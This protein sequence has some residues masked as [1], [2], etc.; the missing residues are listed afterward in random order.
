MPS[1]ADGPSARGR[2]VHP[3]G[4]WAVSF[5]VLGKARSWPCK[6]LCSLR[7]IEDN[8]LSY[9]ATDGPTLK[10]PLHEQRLD[11]RFLASLSARPAGPPHPVGPAADRAHEQPG[12]GTGG[13]PLAP[14]EQTA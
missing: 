5:V 13:A 1:R 14:A 3:G 4:S 9:R 7:R 6:Q 10:K 2:F 11:R 8:L 12:A